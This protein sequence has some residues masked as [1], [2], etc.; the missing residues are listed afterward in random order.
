M[1]VLSASVPPE[2]KNIS[3]GDTCSNLATVLR[4]RSI[5]DRASLPWAWMDEGLPWVSFITL[6]IVINTSGSCGVV[7]ALRSE[8]SREGNESV[9]TCRSRWSPYHKTKKNKKIKR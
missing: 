7:A 8:E 4:E 6:Y 1:A 5:S 9:S 3:A 2:V